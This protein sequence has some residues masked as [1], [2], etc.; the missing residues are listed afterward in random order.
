MHSKEELPVWS[1]IAS[2]GGG[3]VVNRQSRPSRLSIR[4]YVHTSIG[5]TGHELLISYCQIELAVHMN[6]MILSHHTIIYHNTISR[7]R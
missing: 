3:Q 2:D 5:R 7:V 1:I 6:H 4:P